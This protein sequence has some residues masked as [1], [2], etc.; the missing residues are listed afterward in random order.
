MNF[1]PILYEVEKS[2]TEQWGR[3]QPDGSFDGLLGDIIS[4]K[5]DIGLG[6]FHYTPYHLDLIDL[7]LPYNTECLTFLT[8]EAL[9]DNSWQTLI[10]PFKY[11]LSFNF[12]LN[13]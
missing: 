12:N 7:S 13:K 3:K 8:P 6:D 11:E 4:G 1:K 2:S 5:A 9:T 10:L